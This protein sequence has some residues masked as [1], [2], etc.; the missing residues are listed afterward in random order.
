MEPS[1]LTRIR[2]KSFVY[3]GVFSSRWFTVV[4]R[5]AHPKPGFVQ[6]MCINHGGR[7]VLV[8]EQLLDCPDVLPVFKQ[9][10]GE[11]VTKGVT[12]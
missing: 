8:A 4:E 2:R 6:D 5:T 7:N 9:M 1:G 3:F 10:G 11:A 12:A